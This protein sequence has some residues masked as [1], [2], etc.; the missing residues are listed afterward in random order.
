M[1]FL[2]ESI[3][4]ARQARRVAG[5]LAVSVRRDA[6][7]GPAVWPDEAAMRYFMQS[8]GHRRVVA[9]LPEWCD[10]ARWCIGF[11]TAT[12]LG[13]GREGLYSRVNHPTEAAAVWNSP[14]PRS[15]GVHDERNKILFFL[16]SEGK[17]V[18]WVV[19]DIERDREIIDAIE[20]HDDR[21][22]ALAAGAYLENRL[23]HTIQ[24]HGDNSLKPRATFAAKINTAWRLGIFPTQ[25]AVLLHDVRKI[26]NECAH[27]LAYLSFGTP[28]LVGWCNRL[29]SCETISGL[30]AENLAAFHDCPAM[31]ELVTLALDPLLKLPDTPRNKYM[32][33]IKVLLLYLELSKAAVSM[34][35]TDALEIIRGPARYD[36]PQ[37]WRRNF[38]RNIRSARLSWAAGFS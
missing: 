25:M 38:F 19:R 12:I 22:A 23:T 8:G 13:G 26:R 34:G 18:A 21:S 15:N 27:G 35:E 29:V 6:R 33:T 11:K 20:G 1:G 10:E 31:L 16:G 14:D 3:H 32:A 4:S 24:A 28:P 7:F 9:R 5:N 36:P 37:Q 17:H 2:I 30:R